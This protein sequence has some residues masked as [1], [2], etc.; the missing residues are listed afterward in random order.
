ML[1]TFV[2]CARS[3][4]VLLGHLFLAAP[5]APSLDPE[6]IK[7]RGLDK[8]RLLV[9]HEDNPRNSEGSFLELEDGRLLFVYTH[10]TGGNGDH[11]AAH[12]ASRLSRDG[13]Y[14]WTARDKVLVP[15]EG[16]MNVSS[17]SLLRLQSGEIALFY[18]RKN[19]H[20]DCRAYLRLSRNEGRRWGPPLLCM[21]QGGYFTVHNDRVLQLQSGRLLIPAARHNVPGGRWSPR[22]VAVCFLSDDN[23]QTWHS[24]RFA[25]TGPE[26]S[27]TGLQDPAVV[28]LKDGRLL[29]LCSTDQGCPYR[30]YSPDGGETWSPAEPTDLRSPVAPV[31]LKRIPSTGDLLLVWNDHS[32]VAP[33]RRTKRTPLAVALSCDEGQTWEKTKVLEDDPAGWYCYTAVT[34]VAERVLLAY[35]AG[36]QDVGRLNRTQITVCDLNWLYQEGPPAGVALAT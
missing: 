21:S 20:E 11:S 9:P 29:M 12:L 35:C 25:L 6:V 32:Q 27:R 30:S 2:R 5:A 16:Q 17:A 14:T 36:G 15:N 19:S 7:T 13:G 4:G 10:F 33:A 34:F 28:E 23:G 22:G 18:L 26:R 31:A 8:L 3:A 1:D 24:S